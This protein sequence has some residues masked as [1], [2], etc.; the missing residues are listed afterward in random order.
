[1]ALNIQLGEM[2]KDEII[3]NISSSTNI[4]N[5][6]ILYNITFGI[7]GEVNTDWEN[8]FY[9]QINQPPYNSINIFGMSAT[10]K[11]F[12]LNNINYDMLD[13][14]LPILKTLIGLTNTQYNYKTELINNSD[15][16]I[17]YELN[18]IMR[19]NG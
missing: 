6:K 7:N 2:L 5:N 15:T 11:K 14:F 10:Y 18:K 19:Y 8:E 3:N 17:Q 1:M 9:V 16:L 12:I 13:T 4:Q